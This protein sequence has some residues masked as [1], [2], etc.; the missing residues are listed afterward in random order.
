MFGAR[1][2]AE[3]EGATLY[4]AKGCAACG[5]TG[6]RGR[7]GI[8][9]ALLV[10]DELEELIAEKSSVVEIRD[11]ALKQGMITLRKSGLRRV[12]TGETSI[13]EVLTSTMGDAP[14]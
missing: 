14:T 9:E 11:L 7:R 4:E 13:D 10:T 8:F 6:Y 5:K 2:R 3:L 12:A 1:E